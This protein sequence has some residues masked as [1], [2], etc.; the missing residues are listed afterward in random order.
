T[1]VKTPF[2]MSKFNEVRHFMNKL[3]F[4]LTEG[5]RN[6]LRSISLKMK[7]GKRVNAMVQGDVGCGKTIV[8]F[9]LMMVAAENGFQSALM[10]PTN[11]LA[12]QHYEELSE[13]LEGTPYKVA[14]LS[15][16]MKVREKK[17]VLKGLKN[18]E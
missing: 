16:D 2:V 5:Q 12:K 7:T 11:V 1:N 14:F 4:E 3:P 9:L 13:K 17:V 15:G 6:T 8:A 10:A 18:G